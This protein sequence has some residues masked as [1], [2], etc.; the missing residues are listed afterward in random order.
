M[1]STGKKL[2]H[3]VGLHPGREYWELSYFIILLLPD[4][5]ASFAIC[6]YHDTLCYHKAKVTAWCYRLKPLKWSQNLPTF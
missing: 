1:G 4:E 5:E 2:G 6:Y 3:G